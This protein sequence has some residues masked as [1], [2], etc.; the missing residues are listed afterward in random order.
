MTY[1][2]I[3][4]ATLQDAVIGFSDEGMQPTPMVISATGMFLV[5]DMSGAFLNRVSFNEDISGWDVSS[6]TSTNNLF[7]GASSF[8]QPIGN[9]DVSS[10]TSM[11]FMF[12]GALPLIIK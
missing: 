1:E 5:T 2:P 4:D 3:T 9:W 11:Q 12:L 8:N 7:R 6:V 10:V